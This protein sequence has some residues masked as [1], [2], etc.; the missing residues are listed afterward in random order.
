MTL[1]QRMHAWQA[2]G[3]MRLC[4]SALWGW[5][6]GSGHPVSTVPSYC[7]WPSVW[8]VHVWRARLLQAPLPGQLL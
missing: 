2:R 8:L 6:D 7:T 1:G 4:L 3:T 5:V